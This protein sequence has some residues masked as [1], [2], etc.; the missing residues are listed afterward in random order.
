MLIGE[1]NRYCENQVK[2]IGLLVLQSKMKELA[3]GIRCS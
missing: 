1:A 2:A 3:G